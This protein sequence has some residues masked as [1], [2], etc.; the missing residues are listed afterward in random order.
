MWWIALFCKEKGNSTEKIFFLVGGSI[1]IILHHVHHHHHHPHHHHQHHHPHHHHHHHHH[2]RHHH[3]HHAHFP[4]SIHIISSPPSLLPALSTHRI[5]LARLCSGADPL[6]G[7]ERSKFEQSKSYWIK[8]DWY[9][10]LVRLSKLNRSMA[11]GLVYSTC[12]LL[13][14][15]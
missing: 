14:Y 12:S 6:G 15:L 10:L 5:L 1:I 3:S 7:A 13:I 9:N 2:H 4:T 8:W 11:M